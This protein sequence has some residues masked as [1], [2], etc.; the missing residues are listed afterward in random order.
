MKNLKWKLVELNIQGDV[1][2]KILMLEKNHDWKLS[3]SLD[4]INVDETSLIGHTQ[5]QEKYTF[6]LKNEVKISSELYSH[7]N[8]IVS[9][10]KL[11]MNDKDYIQLLDSED[12][13]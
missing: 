10:M 8:E 4:K 9:S 2:Y 12:Y 7:F 5:L 1:I 11:N 6:L 3:K 13:F